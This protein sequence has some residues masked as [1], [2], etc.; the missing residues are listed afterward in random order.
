[1]ERAGGTA[2]DPQTVDTGV[3]SIAVVGEETELQVPHFPVAALQ[4]DTI[5]ADEVPNPSYNNQRPTR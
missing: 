5:E 3:V 4:A 1:M 2:V